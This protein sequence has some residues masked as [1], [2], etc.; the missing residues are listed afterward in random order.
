[1]ESV[2]RPHL[3]HKEPDVESTAIKFADLTSLLVA[4][5]FRHSQT[6]AYKPV[7]CA[8]TVDLGEA[9]L[10]R[11]CLHRSDTQWTCD[12][13]RQ[14]RSANITN[15]VHGHWLDHFLVDLNAV[16][17]AHVRYVHYA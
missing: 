6:G 3:L 2:G 7:K 13:A 8:A 17:A 4:V 5:L 1:M 14:T 11:Q 12:A 9:R 10:F 15:R 16:A